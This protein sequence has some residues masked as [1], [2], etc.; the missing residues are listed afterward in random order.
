MT[1]ESSTPSAEVKRFPIPICEQCLKLEGKMCH[2]PS[3]VFIRR[4]MPEVR[5]YLDVLYPWVVR[6]LESRFM[7][8]QP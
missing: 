8:S 2:N 7:H 6:P 3:C 4:T 5:E 1:K